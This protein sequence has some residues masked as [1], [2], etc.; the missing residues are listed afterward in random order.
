ME[1]GSRHTP[2]ASTAS[3]S[4]LK[5]AQ[6]Y[7]QKKKSAPVVETFQHHQ[8][9]GN[10]RFFSAA[11]AQ[12]SSARKNDSKFKPER[13]GHQKKAKTSDSEFDIFS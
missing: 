5:L 1:Q 6:E 12:D 9:L 10:K 7:S 11:A 13:K 4:T 2:Y 8:G 3:S